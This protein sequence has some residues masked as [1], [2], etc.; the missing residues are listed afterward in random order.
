MRRAP[1]QTAQI[2]GALLVALA[3]AAVAIAVVTAHFGPT[4]SAALEAQEDRIDARI[5][6]R[7]EAAKNRE[8][9]IEERRDSGGNKGPH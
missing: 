4:S 3:T 6:A 5:D 9:A 2:V 1:S 7:E 8:D